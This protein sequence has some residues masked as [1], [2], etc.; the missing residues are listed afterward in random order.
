MLCKLG[1]GIFGGFKIGTYLSYIT[2]LIIKSVIP[3]IFAL[4]VA[5]FVWGVV[6]FFI[7]GADDEKKKET[8]KQFILWGIIALAVMVSIWGLVR[9][10][11]STFGFNDRVLPGVAPSGSSTGGG[12]GSGTGGDIGVPNDPLGDPPET[13]GNVPS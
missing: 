4:A 2:C 3:L 10:V 12:G 5:G 7:L 8:G 9:I 11:G 13:G 6:Q 1:T